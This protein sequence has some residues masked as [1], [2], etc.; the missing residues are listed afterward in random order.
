MI[1]IHFTGKT[2]HSTDYHFDELGSYEVDDAKAEQLLR[3]FPDQFTR[4]KEAAETGDAKPGQ[5]SPKPGTTQ[6]AK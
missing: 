2:Y 3:D 6:K 1:T 4:T 5:E